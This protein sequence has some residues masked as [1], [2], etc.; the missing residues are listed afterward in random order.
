MSSIAVER[1]DAR[2]AGRVKTGGRSRTVAKMLLVNRRS[3]IFLA[4][5]L[6]LLVG[7]ILALAG[8]I[9]SL[10]GHYPLE[11]LGAFYFQN[12]IH[13]VVT[14]IAYI[15][16]SFI[17]FSRT[18]PS[19]LSMGFMRK[20][21]WRGF[22]CMA[23]LLAFITT[24]IYVAFS[25]IEFATLGYSVGWPVISSG[26]PLM[27]LRRLAPSYLI[28]MMLLYA[29]IWFIFILVAQLVG[30]ILSLAYHRLGMPVGLLLGILSLGFLLFLMGQMGPIHPDFGMNLLFTPYHYDGENLV[31]H[32]GPLQLANSTEFIL[33]AKEQIIRQVSGY[34]FFN[35]LGLV[36][37]YG[38]GATLL[39]KVD[40]R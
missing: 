5:F 33:P 13:P 7:M 26:S 30:A 37:S 22:T 12:S 34:T 15:S 9:T 25:L 2:T 19:I 21:L 6:P 1:N 31:Y 23:I 36:L 32:E 38:I 3:T 29:T 28:F 40:F 10:V 18:A 8:V 17:L 35:T 11:S 16:V 20:D 27:T 14:G 39:K 4:V 24:A